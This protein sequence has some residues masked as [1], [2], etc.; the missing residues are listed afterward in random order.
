MAS[1]R[2]NSAKFMIMVDTREAKTK[3]SALLAAVEEK[4]EVVL[5]CGD[6][7]WLWVSRGRRSS[8]SS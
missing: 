8:S 4:G 1:S 2:V 3:L 5:I 7:N 6:R